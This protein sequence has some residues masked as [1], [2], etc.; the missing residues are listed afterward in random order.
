MKSLKLNRKGQ[1]SIIAALFAAAILISSVMV[2][3]STIRY[4]TNVA[5]PQ[6]M[7][8]VDE[9]NLALKQVL[10]FTVGYYGSVM[11]VTGNSSYAYT[12]SE[13]YLNSGLNN[14]VDINPQWGTS[15][16]ITTLQLGT[17]WFTNSS[18]SQGE[19]NVTYNL[20]G[21]GIYGIAYSISSELSVQVLRSTS[22]EQ[23]YLTVTQDGNQ[24]V[25]SLGRSS[26]KFYLYEDSN[27]TWG[28]VYPSDDP[29]VSSDGTYTLDIPSGINPNSFIIQVQ[30]QRGI[31]VSASSFSHY[32]GTLTFNSTT[33][34]GGNYVNETTTNRGLSTREPTATS[35]RNSKHQ[36]TSMTH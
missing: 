36:T 29:V 9:T 1:F 16:I 10:G 14:I 28:M 24:P 31:M 32:T 30:D 21:L 12:E 19:L 17:Y 20:P 35:Q 33:V 25:V 34:S 27:L 23:V 4:N 3:Y 22:Q 7:N 26:F 6:I 11:Q 2:T 18:Y 13:N 15:F 8:A 5:Q